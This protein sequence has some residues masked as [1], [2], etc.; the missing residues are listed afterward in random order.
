MKKLYE[1][2]EI[3][4]AVIWIVAYVVLLSM[5]DDFSESMGFQK[6]ITAPLCVFLTL[7]LFVWIRK[8]DLS[9]KYG[10]IPFKG[11][12]K[13]YLYFVPLLLIMS[14]NLWNGVTLNMSAAE[15][16]LY[17]LSMLCVGFLEEVIFRG[18]LFKAM[19]KSNVKRAIIVSSVT[20]GLGHIVNLL[21]GRD[22][23]PTLLQV[24]YAVALGFLFTIIFYKGKSLL[25]CIVTHSVTNSLST[26]GVEG[27][28]TYD[29]VIAA[30]LCV[31]SVGYA[32]WILKKEGKIKAQEENE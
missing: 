28:Q 24:C 15:S 9:E 5:A 26:F 8:Y 32:L 3:W 29:M 13:N 10:L 16:A 30:A 23:V 17:V 21:N 18:F 7:V 2:S 19:C 20:F 12:W 1:K 11:N 25:P 27:S 4:F 22:F 6:I 14:V 31:V